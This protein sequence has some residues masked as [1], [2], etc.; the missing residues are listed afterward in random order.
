VWK[1]SYRGFSSTVEY[2]L[3]LDDPVRLPRGYIVNLTRG[4]G[5]GSI[6]RAHERFSVY[7]PAKIRRV[8]ADRESDSAASDLRD[9]RPQRRRRTRGLRV[10][11]RVRLLPCESSSEFPEAANRSRRR[12]PFEW[13][14]PS[15]GRFGHGLLFTDVSRVDRQR[16]DS[17]IAT[18]RRKFELHTTDH[19][20]IIA[21]D[22]PRIWIVG[23]AVA[24]SILSAG[25]HA[26]GFH[27]LMERTHDTLCPSTRELRRGVAVVLHGTARGVARPRCGQVR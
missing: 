9:P 19:D 7:I 4:D 1:L 18:L 5:R 26:E 11:V 16:L 25:R 2:T 20:L 3:R 14:R 6:G 15:D 22:E 23:R 17:L 24:R 27:H 21:K 10:V 12:V 13:A 8:Q